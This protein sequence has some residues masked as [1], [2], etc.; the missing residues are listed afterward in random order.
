MAKYYFTRSC[1]AFDNG[2]KTLKLSIVIFY[3]HV[4][5]RLQLKGVPRKVVLFKQ[6]NLPVDFENWY[7]TRNQYL[8]YDD[9]FQILP[10]KSVIR[11]WYMAVTSPPLPILPIVIHQPHQI[12]VYFI[13]HLQHLPP[14]TNLIKP[15][16]AAINIYNK[17][18]P[19][20]N[21]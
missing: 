20:P 19:C 4:T 11:F 7:D 9:Y 5:V 2:L 8:N 21:I 16:H 18:S 6:W 15:F 10:M 1:K 13:V 17:I 3:L 14:V 12:C